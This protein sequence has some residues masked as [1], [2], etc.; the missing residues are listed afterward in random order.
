[1]TTTKHH[2]EDDMTGSRSRTKG[3]NFEREMA[4]AFREVMPGAEIKRGLAQTRSG[5]EV[6]DV[7]CPYFW[8]ECKRGKATNI[9]AALRQAEAACGDKPLVPVAITRDDRDTAMITMRLDE[10]FDFLGEWWELKN[11]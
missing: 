7:E 10:F 4:I 9:K 5:T 3:H 11:R 6:P 8:I 1:M 2:F